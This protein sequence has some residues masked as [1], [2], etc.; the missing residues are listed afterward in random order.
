MEE[1]AV[2]DGMRK[3]GLL[4]RRTF[5]KGSLGVGAA[6]AAPTVFSRKASAQTEKVLRL[7]HWKH[8]V[9]AYDTYFAGFAKAFGE[10]HKCKVEVDFVGTPER[11][12]GRMFF[13]PRSV[14]VVSQQSSHDGGERRE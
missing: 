1:N 6:L 11:P 5:I 10:K 9:P 3:K 8:F 7:V 12:A 2:S 4:K 13:R 14:R